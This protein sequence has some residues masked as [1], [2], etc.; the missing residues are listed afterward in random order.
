MSVFGARGWRSFPPDS[1]MKRWVS[2]AYTRAMGVIDCPSQSGQW[3]CENT[4]FVG[5]DAL[6]NDPDGALD[7]VPLAGPVID[8]L[9]ESFGPLDLHKAQ[10]SVVRPGY[11][12]P[13][14][15]ETDAAFG[16]RNKRDA[17]HVD[18]LLPIGPDRRRF[19]REPHAF[20]LGLPLN[21]SPVEAGPLV[22]WEGSHTILSRAFQVAFA[23]KS[24]EACRATDLTEIY[25][26][27]RKAVFDTCRR[28]PVCLP[29]GGAVLLHPH[30]LHGVG[31]WP[32]GVAGPAEGRMIAYFR[33]QLGSVRD[34]AMI[35]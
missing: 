22:V 16:Y 1:A 20:I 17:A 21:D 24:E 33:P 30:L 35:A 3:Q 6:D 13:R 34:W 10:V 27:A 12:K 5:L 4:W 7:G 32:E 25:Q 15:G 31:A 8:A 19:L 26:T 18:G 2:A 14:A 28:V 23:E 29:P 9:R 11:P